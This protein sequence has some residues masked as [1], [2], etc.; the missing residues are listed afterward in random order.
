MFNKAV[1]NLMRRG[2][3]PASVTF[4]GFTKSEGRI[5][6]IECP[7]CGVESKIFTKSEDDYIFRN[8]ICED[9]V[10]CGKK[11]WCDIKIPKAVKNVL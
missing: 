7:H 6:L 1:V 3:P 2:R 10:N 8:I 11:I 4:A 5:V 9:T